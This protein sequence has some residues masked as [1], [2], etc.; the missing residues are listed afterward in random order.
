MNECMHTV[1]PDPMTVAL[2]QLATA[3]KEH[4]ADANHKDI[5]DALAQLGQLFLRKAM[6]KEVGWLVGWFVGRLVGVR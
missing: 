2:G 1:Q 6:L 5:A 3:K 4:G